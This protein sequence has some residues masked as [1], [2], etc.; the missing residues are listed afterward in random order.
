MENAPGWIAIAIGAFIIWQV[1]G[2]NKNKGTSRPVVFVPLTSGPARK[3]PFPLF[4]L[5]LLAILA[6][7]FFGGDWALKHVPQLPP[8]R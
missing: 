7:I 3:K 5:I 1:W 8:V 2:R 4:V 6:A